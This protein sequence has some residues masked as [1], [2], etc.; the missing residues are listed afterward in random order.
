VINITDASI[1]NADIRVRVLI[2]DFVDFGLLGQMV[3]RCAQAW[4]F[5][6]VCFMA[7]RQEYARALEKRTCGSHRR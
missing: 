5:S 2:K 6:L 1:V 4:L 3:S 7:I